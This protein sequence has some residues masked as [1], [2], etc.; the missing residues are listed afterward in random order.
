MSMS[1]NDGT[2][3]GP[4]VCPLGRTKQSMKGETDINNIVARYKKTGFTDYV[5]SRTPSYIDVSD[6]SD[7]REAL[8]QVRT[9]DEFFKGLPAKIRS[10]F[11]ND[12]AVFLDFV[13]DPGNRDRMVELGLVAKP[14][15]VPAPVDEVP[16][17]G[18]QGRDPVT[19][20]F[21]SPK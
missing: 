4:L 8:E 2:R 11:Q 12:A 14:P 5:N 7:Y 13:T 6:I 15:V 18:V 16:G 3:G 10:E 20:Q 1:G 19:G 21:T 9:T 17:P